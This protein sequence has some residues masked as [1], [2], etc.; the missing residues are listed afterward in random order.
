M[1]PITQPLPTTSGNAADLAR[2]LLRLVGPAYPAADG[3]A[4]AADALALGSAV[5][6]SRTTNTS[7]LDEAFPDSAAA[8]LSEWE[9]MLRLPPGAG[10]LSTAARRLALTA[11]WRTRFAGTP[12]AIL[13]ALTPLNNGQAPTMRETLARL[14]AASPRRVYAYTVLTAVDPNDAG[15]I[16]PLRATVAVMQPAHTAAFF[17]SKATGG[18]F[19]DDGASLTDNTVL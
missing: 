15:A 6:T 18:F 4:N 17:T 11:R 19:C 12:D 13:R 7:S 9:V 1:P 5:A 16:A 14:S 3:T 10:L 8:L 2:Q